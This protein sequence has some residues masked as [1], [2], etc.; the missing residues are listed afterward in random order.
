MK[1][2]YNLGSTSIGSMDCILVKYISVF[3][4]KVKSLFQEMFP[5]LCLIASCHIFLSCSSY[6][7]SPRLQDRLFISEGRNKLINTILRSLPFCIV[8]KSFTV[9]FLFCGL[10]IISDFQHYI[11]VF[12]QVSVALWSS[13]IMCLKMCA[14]QKRNLCFVLKK[15]VHVKPETFI[16]VWIK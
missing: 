13:F 5:K 3:L 15:K 12:L 6:E 9:L 7:P 10:Y 4:S 14:G 1:P 11:T 16:L 8:V 2:L